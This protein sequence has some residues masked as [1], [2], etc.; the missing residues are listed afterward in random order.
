MRE[1]CSRFA[2]IP[3]NSPHRRMPGNL[4]FF[5]PTRL[6]A[7]G[8]ALRCYLP[9]LARVFRVLIPFRYGRRNSAHHARG[10]FS[11]RAVV[12]EGRGR[13]DPT[14]FLTHSVP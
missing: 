13:V 1:D 14:R 8:Y 5:A 12:G 9:G 11:V 3:G 2:Q 6:Q 4:R 7:G 10:G